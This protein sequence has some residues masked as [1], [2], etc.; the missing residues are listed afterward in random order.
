M[1]ASRTGG[2]PPGVAQSRKQTRRKSPGVHSPRPDAAGPGAGTAPARAPPPG[3]RT[4]PEV[5]RSEPEVT[6]VP[7]AARGVMAE[8]AER[9]PEETLSRWARE[10][11]RLRARVLLADTE[12][13]QRAPGFP[14]LRRVGGVDVSFAGDGGQRACACLVV[15]SFPELEVLFEDQ[16]EV[17]LTAPYVP[18]FLGFRE[19]PLLAQAVQRLRTRAPHLVPQV[20]LVDGNGVL[21]HRG[22]GVACHLGVLTD[23]PCV[24]VAKKLLQVDGLE[25]NAEHREKIRLLRAPGDCFPLSGASGTVLGMALRTHARS[26]KPLYVSVGHRISLEAAVRLTL[27]CC[28]FKNPEPVRQADIRS[29][30]H[31]RRALAGPAHPRGRSPQAPPPPSCAQGDA[32]EPGG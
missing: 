10:Q 29:R 19:A 13:W 18:G 7:E 23:L 15:L 22:F 8:A 24:G 25:N 20:L 12:A 3:T 9:P 16:S 6:R 28:R 5:T 14:G 17:S 1:P 4:V 2:A 26:T 27:S 11:A 32:E 31:L 21:H 30:E